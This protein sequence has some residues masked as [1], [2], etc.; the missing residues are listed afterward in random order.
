MRPDL[1][2]VVPYP[3]EGEGAGGAGGGG[4][5]ELAVLAGRFVTS[6]HGDAY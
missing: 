2:E 1:A 5:R 3:V 4:R 6:S